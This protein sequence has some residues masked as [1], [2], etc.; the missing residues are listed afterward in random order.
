MIRMIELKSTGVEVPRE[1]IATVDGVELTVPKEFSASFALRY[2]DVISRAGLD[3]GSAWLLENALG[4]EGYNTLLGFQELT[5][6]NL[7]ELMAILQGK[8]TG[9]MEAGKEGLKAV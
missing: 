9:A 3:S 8:V 5:A 4:V 2:V 7:A 6:E 1:V